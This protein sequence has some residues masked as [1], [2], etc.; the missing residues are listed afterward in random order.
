MGSVINDEQ[1]EFLLRDSTSEDKHEFGNPTPK[2]IVRLE[3]YFD[4]PDKFKKPINTKKNISSLKYK[5]VNL[6][7]K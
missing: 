5:V 7:K 2:N 6:D 3:K 4:L 1:H